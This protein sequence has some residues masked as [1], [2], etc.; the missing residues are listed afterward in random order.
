MH[1]TRRYLTKDAVRERYG[2]ASKI[3]VDR[4]WQVYGT[5]PP[6]TLYQGNRPI[7][8][9]HILDQHDEARRFDP[10]AQS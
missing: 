9:E 6:P 1:N 7:W 3:S 4:A 10:E 2:W 8:A 5:L